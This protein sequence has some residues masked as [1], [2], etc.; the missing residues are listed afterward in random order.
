MELAREG[1]YLTDGLNLS[2]KV[3]GTNSRFRVST[4]EPG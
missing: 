2:V 3:L 1:N 4:F